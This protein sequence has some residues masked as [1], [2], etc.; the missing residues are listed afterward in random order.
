MKTNLKPDFLSEVGDEM[1]KGGDDAY[2]ADMQDEGDE[3]EGDESTQEDLIL[4]GKQVAK[5]LGVT[6]ADPAKFATALKSF[7]AAC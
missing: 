7:V 4:A 3:G 5:A 1:D 2:G 6:P